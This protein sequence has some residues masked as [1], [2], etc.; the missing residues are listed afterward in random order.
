MIS[1]GLLIRYG[2]LILS[3][4]PKEIIAIFFE[5]GDFKTCL[6]NAIRALPAVAPGTLVST[7]VTSLDQISLMLNID[8]QQLDS[9]PSADEVESPKIM[10][11]FNYMSGYASSL[12]TPSCEPSPKA[13]SALDLFRRNIAPK[14]KN[15]NLVHMP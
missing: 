7:I 14:I 4:F 8:D 1:D 5:K 10:I 6:I 3:Q 13:F 2:R 12:T 15:L 11:F 9:P